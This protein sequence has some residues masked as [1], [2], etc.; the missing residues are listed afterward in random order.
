MARRQDQTQTF[1]RT[2]LVYVTNTKTIV[3]RNS[4]YGDKIRSYLI[5]KNRAL[6]IDEPEDLEI[7]ESML[8]KKHGK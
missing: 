5:D 8:R 2:G 1:I 4:L 7:A 6:A 3:S